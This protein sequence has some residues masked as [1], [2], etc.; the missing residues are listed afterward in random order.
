[1]KIRLTKAGKRFNREWIFRNA[2]LEFTSSTSYAIT[3][4]NGSGKSTLLQCIGGMLQLSEGNIQYAPDSYQ[5]GNGQ[6]ANEEVYREISF[7]AP[8]L[9]V[10]EE[11]N[12]VE[13]LRFHNQFKPFINGFII[14]QI[15][16]EIEL[17]EAVH[18]QIRLYSS[19]MKQRVKLA[20][21]IFSDTS[22]VLLD[23]PCTNLDAKGIELY[24]SLIER[25]C[26]D[27]LVIVSSN[28][29]TEYNFCE[30]IIPIVQYKQTLT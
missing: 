25:Y 6:L 21:A 17:K 12:L 26:K 20:Q 11:M 23:E 7:C 1:M 24:H 10:I 19:G 16:E 13:F 3:G 14:E 28:D 8:Y 2:D 5:D 15:I 22:I 27:R 18:K 30:Q 4:P 29:E 9:D